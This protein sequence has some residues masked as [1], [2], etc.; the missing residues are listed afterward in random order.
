MSLLEKLLK[1]SKLRRQ[2][3]LV[4]EAALDRHADEIEEERGMVLNAYLAGCADVGSVE[5]MRSGAGVVQQEIE[6]LERA[7]LAM[8]RITG[9]SGGTTREA[10]AESND[11]AES[12]VAPR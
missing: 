7:R 10:E 3:Y 1:R 6:A 2:S 4:V 12:E 11:D 9:G 5:M 8:E